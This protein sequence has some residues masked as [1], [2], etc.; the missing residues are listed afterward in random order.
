MLRYVSLSRNN[1][2]LKVYKNVLIES[3]TNIS[4]FHKLV[5]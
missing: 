4:G 5:V 1:R 2:H 3:T